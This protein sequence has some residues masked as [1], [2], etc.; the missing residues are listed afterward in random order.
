MRRLEG[1]TDSMDLSLGELWEL[2][3]DR[4]AWH[5]VH[6]VAKNQTRLSNWTELNWEDWAQNCTTLATDRNSSRPYRKPDIKWKT[7]TVKILLASLHNS[8]SPGLRESFQGVSV[9]PILRLFLYYT[10]KCWNSMSAFQ[11]LQPL[12][13]MTAFPALWFDDSLGNVAQSS[14]LNST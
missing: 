5:A 2:V 11:Q 14:T 3:M 13:R 6:G 1:I 9:H 10:R 7:I 8:L 4:E 12:R